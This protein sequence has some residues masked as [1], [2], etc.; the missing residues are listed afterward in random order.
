MRRWRAGGKSTQS[1]RMAS[2]HDLPRALKTV[3]PWT[4]AMR[5]WKEMADDAVFVWAAALAYSWLFAIFPFFIFLLSLIP[6]LPADIKAQAEDP[7]KNAIDAYLPSPSANDV[8]QNIYRVMHQTHTG[9][10]SVGILVTVWAASGGMNMTMAALDRVYDVQKPRPFYK[11]RPIAVGL[12]VIVAT[13]I[14]AVLVLLPV[15][16]AVTH[17]ILEHDIPYFTRFVSKPVIWTWNVARYCLAVL[18]LF[19]SVSITYYFGPSVKQ[20]FHILTPGSVFTISMWLILGVGFR[21]YVEKYGKYDKTYGTVAGVAILLLL[22]YIDAV[23]LLIG[24]EINSEI[25]FAVGVPRGSTDFRNP[26]GQDEGG[27]VA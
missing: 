22:F 2:L 27:S 12:T 15:G 9:L 10:L 19:A 6:Y 25:D 24:A 20:R 3:R 5:V 11:Q 1:R 17:F 4:L 18:L 23:V 8:W 7:I 21:L 26:A 16:T 14:L 13:L